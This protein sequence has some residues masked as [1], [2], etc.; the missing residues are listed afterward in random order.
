MNIPIQVERP[1][2]FIHLHSLVLHSPHKQH[3]VDCRAVVFIQPVE[4]LV[5]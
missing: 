5:V 1:P 3:I 2:N 4:K